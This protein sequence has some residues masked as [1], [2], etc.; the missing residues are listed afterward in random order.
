M[1]PLFRLRLLGTPQVTLN[2]QPVR[3]FE[4]RKALAFLCYVAVRDE[5]LSRTHLADLFWGDKPEAKGRGNLSRVLHNLN[6]LFPNAFHATRET[7]Q[8]KPAVFSLDLREFE[9]DAAQATPNGLAAAALLYRDEFM[10]GL[11]LD[12]CAEFE[13]WLVQERERWQQRV[14]SVLECL[15]GYYA[16]HGEF[17][18]A[19]PFAARLLEIEPWREETHRQMM[20]LLS[21][22]GQRSAALQQY[23]IAQRVLREEMG[24]EPSSE[25]I[26][27]YEQIR[28]EEI[29]PISPS[30]IRHNL[31]TAL[32]SFFGRETEIA[33]ITAR[34]NNPDCRLLTIVG[35]GGIGKTRLAL[36]AAANSL[37]SYRDGVYFVPLASIPPGQA[38]FI[39]SAIAKAVGFTFAGTDE[40]KIQLL[41]FLHEKQMLLLLDNFEHLIDGRGLVT[42][43]LQL[44]PSLKLLVTSREPLNLQAEWLIRVLGLSYPT[45]SLQ[46]GEN[47]ARYSALKL[48]AERA[49]RLDEHFALTQKSS[50]HIIRICQIVEGMPLAIELAAAASK[51]QPIHKIAEQ[52]GHNLDLMQTSLQDM[53]TRHQSLRGV[54]DWSYSLL[55]DVEQTVFRQLSVFVGEWT[56]EA[57]RDICKGSGIAGDIIPSTLNNLV[58]KSLVLRNEING[59]FRYHML[60]PVQQFG[61]ECLIK[62]NEMRA[63]KE[64]HLWFYTTFAEEKE[65]FLVDTDQYKWFCTIE[66]EHANLRGALTW[67]VGEGD[68]RL[69][70]RLAKATW[71]FWYRRDYVA[72]GAKW[73]ELI[74]QNRTTIRDPHVLA[75][76]N[77]QL[78]T[79]LIVQGATETAHFHY[80]EARLLAAACDDKHTLSRSLGGLGVIAAIQRNPSEAEEFLKNSLS[81]ARQANG[82]HL[83]AEALTTMGWHHRN[84]GEINPARAELEEAVKLFTEVGDLS[85]IA[86]VKN[87]LGVL[88]YLMGDYNDSY[89]YL[90]DSLRISQE[91]SNQRHAAIAF[92]SLGELA[93]FQSNI[94]ESGRLLRDGLIR[95]M[96]T[97]NRIVI[98]STLE[99]LGFVAVAEG[100]FWRSA[101]ILGAAAA[102][103]ERTTI[104][105]PSY[106]ETHYTNAVASLQ[107]EMEPPEFSLSWNEGRS[108]AIGQA[109]TYAIAGSTL[110]SIE[111]KL[112]DIQ[113]S[114]TMVFDF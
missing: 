6:D 43:Y 86:E 8:L 110:P 58:D 30:P 112:F 72:E 47:P 67:S 82:K 85:A 84:Q 70:A 55:K 13:V 22:T 11:F 88:S 23:E 111:P 68:I 91:M 1:D 46:N 57:A 21:Q 5:P 28:R 102:A 17:S 64:R 107:K 49:N 74:L 94:A 24:I 109:V 87:V 62:A 95:I 26:S 78:G 90:S 48:F 20:Q 73:L 106:L 40:P 44:A 51:W 105:R 39:I 16:R 63:L 25:T 65:R 98:P 69:G 36:E 50:P 60:E 7:I 83:I 19:L 75:A 27:L 41:N 33:R 89:M 14:V 79:F 100:Q 103:R 77:W 31:P 71:S 56:L 2:D 35:T 81:L 32:T 52:I 97:G 38:D 80:S 54:L 114:K 92:L 15:S 18:A 104:R 12:D 29:A 10:A 61:T 99:F 113:N 4:S 101:K 108:M 66:Y 53:D 37:G 9:R 3:G 42:E 45:I 93:F 59:D 34:L 96:R 76:L